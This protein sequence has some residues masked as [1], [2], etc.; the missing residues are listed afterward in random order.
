MVPIMSQTNPVNTILPYFPKMHS[1]ITLPFMSRSSD[2]YLPFR[3]SHQKCITFISQP[4][5][6]WVPGDSS[7]GVKLTTHLDLAPRLR[8]RGAIPPLTE[9][10]LVMR[11]DNFTFT[12]IYLIMHWD[13]DSSVSIGT[14]LRDGRSWF[15]AGKVQRF[16]FVTT[17]TPALGFTHLLS[18]EYQ[19]ILPWG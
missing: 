12:F 7:P 9:R 10:W 17:S 3:F 11:G 1:D 19:E 15:D 6:Q 13:W 8:M 18:N 2:W 4:P 16:F 14:R 5:I